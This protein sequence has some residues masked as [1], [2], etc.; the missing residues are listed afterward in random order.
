MS[1]TITVPLLQ[2][3][4]RRDANTIVPSTVFPHELLMLRQM[5]GKEN[6]HSE[7]QVGT[8]EID[9]TAEFAR[10]SHKYGEGK[11]VKVYGDDGGDRLAELIEKAAIKAEKAE[12]PAKGKTKT[13]TT[14]ATD[15]AAE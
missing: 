1:K 7:V 5:F 4:V 10:M 15:P 2:V 3:T 8:R 13:E 11:V 6:V 14:E 9:P 12:K